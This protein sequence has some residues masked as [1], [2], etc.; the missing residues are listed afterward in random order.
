MIAT[1]WS[2][3]V[4]ASKFDIFYYYLKV[5]PYYCS[6]HPAGMLVLMQNR[7]S[8]HILQCFLN[9]N[10]ISPFPTAR[11][12][13]RPDPSLNVNSKCKTRPRPAAWC[14]R[15]VE[16]KPPPTIICANG[17]QH[18][19]ATTTAT[20]QSEMH[21]QAGWNKKKEVQH[22]P[23]LVGNWVRIILWW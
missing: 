7:S 17:W 23:G 18:N 16:T 15:A 13:H 22:P 3:Q 9:Q 10:T 21:L 12:R 11:P 2:S 14:E 20:G 8:F 6:K 1:I 5:R 19:G 4:V